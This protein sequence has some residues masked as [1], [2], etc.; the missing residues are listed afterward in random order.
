MKLAAG[1]EIAD[2]FS[3]GKTRCLMVKVQGQYFVVTEKGERF[4]PFANASLVLPTDYRGDRVAFAALE[5]QGDYNRWFVYIDGKKDGPFN[6]LESLCASGEDGSFAYAVAVATSKEQWTYALLQEGKPDKKIEFLSKTGGYLK[7]FL[8]WDP[9]SADFLWAAEPGYAYETYFTRSGKTIVCRRFS[10]GF[11]V[12]PKD[13]RLIYAYAE[14]K[15]SA[16]VQDGKETYGPYRSVTHLTLNRG[17]DTV[18]YLATVKQNPKDMYGTIAP[19]TAGKQL[20]GFAIGERGVE[21]YVAP[22]FSEDGSL[23]SWGVKFRKANTSIEKQIEL[24]KKINSGEEVD[25][26]EVFAGA[27]MAFFLDKR[28]GPCSYIQLA[29]LIDADRYEYVYAANGEYF[30]VRNGTTYGPFPGLVSPKDSKITAVARFDGALAA[31]HNRDIQ[32]TLDLISRFDAAPLFSYRTDDGKKE[33]YHLMRGT[34]EIGAFEEIYGADYTLDGKG[35][36]YAAKT[37]SGSNFVSVNGKKRSLEGS[38]QTFARVP[39]VD[40]PLLGIYKPEAETV[41]FKGKAYGPFYRIER[42][43][44]S[45]NGGFRLAKGNTVIAF[46]AWIKGRAANRWVIVNETLY[47]GI[48]DPVRNEVRFLWG[49]KVMAIAD[50][51]P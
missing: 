50:A 4:G 18:S 27:S 1:E 31:R 32:P 45:A 40:E 34:E 36:V 30:L 16:W 44:Y 6:E 39:G 51:R 11:I 9:V 42:D 43:H 33:I 38:V 26:Y 7:S 13:G 47:P 49:D 37:K 41:L 8:V 21:D 19:Y 29:R 48:V 20:P 10:D 5:K 28:I 22:V 2:I 17:N 35:L 3:I 46:S 14:S 12:S 24:I 25:F 15:G 23:A